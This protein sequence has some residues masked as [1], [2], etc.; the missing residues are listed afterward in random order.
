M[1]SLYFCRGL[2]FSGLPLIKQG[3]ADAFPVPHTV[4][5]A[6]SFVSATNAPLALG[7]LGVGTYWRN[8]VLKFVRLRRLCLSRGAL[9]RLFVGTEQR[10]VSVRT[11][12]LV[13]PR[14]RLII[15]LKRCDVRVSVRPR[16][17]Y[18]SRGALFLSLFLSPRPSQIKQRC[19]MFRF[20]LSS[21]WTRFQY[22]LVSSL[23]SF[24]CRA[25]ATTVLGAVLALPAV[26][27]WEVR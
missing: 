22:R 1:R 18:F 19:S 11:G 21:R 2:W 4:K 24:L 14:E 25:A 9:F 8:N 23:H 3:V 26:Y 20:L 6:V 17:W 10:P 16:R 5:R 13:W 12:G 15:S 7:P 27:L